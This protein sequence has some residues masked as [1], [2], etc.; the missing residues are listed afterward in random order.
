MTPVCPRPV[1][2]IPVL[3][4]DSVGV[5][6]GKVH[7]CG[8]K[9]NIRDMSPGEGGCHL[10]GMAVGKRTS[11]PWETFSSPAQVDDSKN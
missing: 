3:G 7:T 6:K 10:R 5:F 1:Y 2:Y 8:H 9:L 4:V 11:I